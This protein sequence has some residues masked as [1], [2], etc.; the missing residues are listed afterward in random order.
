MTGS[1]HSREKLAGLVGDA[2]AIEP[3][4]CLKYSL[5][6]RFQHGIEAAQ[7]GH[8]QDD[9]AIF[10]ADVQVAQGVGRAARDEVGDPL[11]VVLFHGTLTVHFSLAAHTSAA[12][13]AQSNQSSISTLANPLLMLWQCGSSPRSFLAIT[14]GEDG[15]GTLYLGF[16]SSTA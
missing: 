5:F 8:G 1:V 7:H 12:Q 6:F 4:L 10:P 16:C 2:C 11:W 3:S 13:L 9:V 14:L 15:T